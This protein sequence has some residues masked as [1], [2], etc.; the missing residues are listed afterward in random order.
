MPSG[1]L[2]ARAPVMEK[3]G[4]LAVDEFSRESGDSRRKTINSTLGSCAA[5]TAASEQAS[6][7]HRCELEPI[8]GATVDELPSGRQPHGIAAHRLA[9]PAVLA[10]LTVPPAP[11]C[12]RWQRSSSMSTTICSYLQGKALLSV[13]YRRTGCE[14]FLAACTHGGAKDRHRPAPIARQAMEGSTVV[15]RRTLLALPTRTAYVRG[16]TIASLR[17]A[18][19]TVPR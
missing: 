3:T 17:A 4:S 15:Q 16:Q 13:R 1:S 8:Q 12:A 5:Q 18:V 11:T 6:H 19:T 2:V 10:V 7:E 14:G 9:C